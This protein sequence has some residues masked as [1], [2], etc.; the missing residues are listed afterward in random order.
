MQT[1]GRIDAFVSGSG[2]G[3]TISG[4]ASYLRMQKPDVR[5]ILADPEGS[6]LFNRVRFRTMFASQEKEGTKRRH[7]VDTIVEGIG[8]NRLTQNFKN[9]EALI[10]DAVKV[11]D[12]EALAMSRWL[13]ERDGL[14]LGS[15]SAVN[16]VASVREAL[17]MRKRG[18]ATGTVVTILCDHGH[19]HYSKFWN[20]SYL[21]DHDYKVDTGV[22]EALLHSQVSQT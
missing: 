3:G 18:V 11:T 14:F 10:N 13:V 17:A 19:R 9:G 7:Q 21:D 20:Q 12:H 22:I 1:G 6:G 15:S 5:V 2:T 16:L 4:V 8:L